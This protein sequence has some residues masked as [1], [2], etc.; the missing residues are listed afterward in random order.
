MAK[1]ETSINGSHLTT[2]ARDAIA[3]VEGDIIY[4]TTTKEY[5]Y[6]TGSAWSSFGGSVSGASFGDIWAANTLNN[7]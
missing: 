5:Q 4:N 6:W 3:A 1:F 2:A 7:C